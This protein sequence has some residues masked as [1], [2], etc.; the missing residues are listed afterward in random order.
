MAELGES[1]PWLATWIDTWGEI[2]QKSLVILGPVSDDK[3]TQQKTENN[4]IG[5]N[6]KLP[7]LAVDIVDSL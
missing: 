7:L 4:S 1:Q 5:S 2:H 3:L 6:L